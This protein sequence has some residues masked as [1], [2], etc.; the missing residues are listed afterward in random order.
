MPA[1]WYVRADTLHT[2]NFVHVFKGRVWRN[3]V[4]IWQ[5]I[6]ICQQ[7]TISTFTRTS[8]E[9]NWHEIQ[10]EL[11]LIYYMNCLIFCTYSVD[12]LCKPV[13]QSFKKSFSLT[14]DALIIVNHYILF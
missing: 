12:Y 8:V 4:V 9:P 14:R 6:I 5:L 7:V 10:H 1:M 13:S 11:L 3:T 2:H